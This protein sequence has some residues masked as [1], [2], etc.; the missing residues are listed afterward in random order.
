VI[1]PNISTTSGREPL[2]RELRITGDDSRLRERSCGNHQDESRPSTPAGWQQRR[3]SRAPSTIPCGYLV[4]RPS[5][6]STRSAR[7]A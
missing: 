4:R 3:S 5:P 1:T 6:S 7:R 2:P